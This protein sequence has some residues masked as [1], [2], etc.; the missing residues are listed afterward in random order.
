MKRIFLVAILL[1]GGALS[2][3]AD[4]DTWTDMTRHSRSDDVLHADIDSCE[5]R[6][7]PN[8]NGVPTTRSLKQC[9]RTRGW[10]FDHTTVEKTWIDPETGLTCRDMK[11]FGNV[12]GSNCSNF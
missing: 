9:M 2:A 5:Q 8:L 3:H 7:G 1:V 10:R 6:V 4:N 11:A 12:I